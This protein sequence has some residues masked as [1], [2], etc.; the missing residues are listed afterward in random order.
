MSGP[1]ASLALV[2]VDIFSIFPGFIESPLRESL[3]GKAIAKAPVIE[4][5][6]TEECRG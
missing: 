2:R 5:T 4:T 3:V 1:V 6:N